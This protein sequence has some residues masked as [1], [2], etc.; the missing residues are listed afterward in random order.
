MNP[1]PHTLITMKTNPTLLC[2][3]L[4]ACTVLVLGFGGIVNAADDKKAGASAP[5]KAALTVT[6]TQ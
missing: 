4:A 6:V 2:A 3:A 1:M 5:A